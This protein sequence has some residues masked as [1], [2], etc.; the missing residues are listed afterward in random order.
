[1]IGVIMAGARALFAGGAGKAAS[2]TAG[3]VVK[4][5]VTGATKRPAKGAGGAT[6]GGSGHDAQAEKLNKLWAY[7]SQWSIASRLTGL[8]GD[9]TPSFIHAINVSVIGGPQADLRRVWFLACAA[10]FGRY[11]NRV[12]GVGQ[13]NLDAVWD[14]T[15]KS[16]S[17]S[18]A[19]IN[20]GFS[21][22][23]ANVFRSG[24][25]PLIGG[26]ALL[27]GVVNILGGGFTTG[28]G[29]TAVAGT[30][31]TQL[32]ATQFIQVGPDQV[33][34]GGG[35]P[36]FMQQGSSPN[37]ATIPADL[38]P[39][40][41]MCEAD[42]GRV[43]KFGKNPA[44]DVTGEVPI[45][46]SGDLLVPWGR[47]GPVG[48]NTV[49][50]AAT[51]GF[52]S[53]LLILGNRIALPDDGRLIT[54]GEKLDPRVQPPKPVIDGKSRMSVVAAIHAALH[55]PCYAPESVGCSVQPLYTPGLR[56]YPAGKELEDNDLL[57]QT[58][59]SAALSSVPKPAFEPLP[60]VNEPTLTE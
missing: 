55:A 25:T 42:R 9:N 50:P 11:R 3:K 49:H 51:R 30:G 38:P 54:T 56:V 15:G 34:V 45:R 32:S 7:D 31:R 43:L 36:D 12:K 48:L 8:I 20:S 5:A 39:Q 60:A 44:V 23:L 10:A 2:G 19:Y 21:N 14:V 40:D 46:K 58:K 26:P 24:A 59:F 33:T 57:S 13:A 22:V 47:V 27:L 28:P 29:R 37:P 18:I 35:W 16:V 41:E 52:S 4:A 17:V 1:M 6:G 53:N